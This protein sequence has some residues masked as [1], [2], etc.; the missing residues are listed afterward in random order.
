MTPIAFSRFL[1][2]GE[3]IHNSMFL[4]KALIFNFLIILKSLQMSIIFKQ[5][6]DILIFRSRQH[7]SIQLKG[8]SS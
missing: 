2:V 5:I 3:H 4:R 6:K 8:E 1:D 7:F